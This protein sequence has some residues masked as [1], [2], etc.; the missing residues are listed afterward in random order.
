MEKIGNVYFV[1]R[2]KEPGSEFI[3]PEC[4]DLKHKILICISIFPNPELVWPGDENMLHHQRQK[5][6]SLYALGI[7][8]WEIR[9]AVKG[10][11][12]CIDIAAEFPN[13]LVA[14]RAF[15]QATNIGR[16]VDIYL[17]DNGKLVDKLD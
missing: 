6:S 1:R 2:T 10:H 11:D 14:S 7:F 13:I 12:H 17:Y 15:E 5:M 3:D 16:I 8:N 4:E 9:E